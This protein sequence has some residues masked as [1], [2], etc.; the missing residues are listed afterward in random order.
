MPARAWLRKIRKRPGVSGN[1]LSCSDMLSSVGFA[2]LTRKT[3]RV[4]SGANP[5]TV[6]AEQRRHLPFVETELDRLFQRLTAS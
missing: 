3:S 4:V 2:A 1:R 6:T 5:C